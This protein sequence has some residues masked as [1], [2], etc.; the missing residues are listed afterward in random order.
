MERFLDVTAV[1]SGGSNAMDQRRISRT[2][3]QAAD[4]SAA[5]A[6]GSAVAA[7]SHVPVERRRA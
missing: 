4:P 2:V 5:V 1:C 3:R 7:R 6:S